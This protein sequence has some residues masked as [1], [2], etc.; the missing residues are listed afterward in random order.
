[1]AAHCIAAESETAKA[2]HGSN[3]SLHSTE[4]KFIQPT[5]MLLVPYCGGWTTSES[6][7]LV[8]MPLCDYPPFTVTCFQPTEYYEGVGCRSFD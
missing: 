2:K 1:M 6:Q 8:S 3:A 7:L 5:P 4:L